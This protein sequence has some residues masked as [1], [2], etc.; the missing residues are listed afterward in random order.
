MKLILNK[1]SKHKKE[2]K[3]FCLLICKHVICLV[4]Y[5]NF[6]IEGIMGMKMK[7]MKLKNFVNFVDFEIEFNGDLTRLVGVNKSGKTTLGLTAVWAAFKGIAENGAEGKLIGDRFRFIGTSGNS[8]DI[9]ITLI[10]QKTNSE[11]KVKNHITKNGNKIT[12]DAP[13]DYSIDSD[14]VKNLLSVSF[15]SAKHFTQLSAKEQALALGIDT[16]SF[17]NTLANL[18][19]EYTDI[20]RAV[21]SFGDITVP[22]KVEKVSISSLLEDKKKIDTFNQRQDSSQKAIDSI[23]QEISASQLRRKEI[24]DE[25][26]R[27]NEKK[28]SI[29]QEIEYKKNKISKL[30]IPEPRK[31]VGEI[32]FKIE[33]AESNNAKADAY[34]VALAKQNNKATVQ[35][36]LEENKAEQS[37]VVNARLEY[38][39]KFD[40]GF[41]GLSVGDDGG[42]L[43]R[44]RPL[45]D[46][47]FSKGELEVLIAKLYMYKNPELKVRFIDDFELLDDENQE[48]LIQEMTQS[49]FQV[50]TAEVGKEKKTNNTVLLRECKIVDS[51]NE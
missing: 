11:I 47:Y 21:K 50:I 19:D 14:W 9:E 7:R 37:R 10:D 16:S 18:K 1:A 23:N 17:D 31:D 41:D 29:E 12:F 15:L 2:I 8:S 44:D 4:L 38:I 30:P 32:E 36:K 35:K 43:Y 28:L 6:L 46:A 20:N 42:L 24:I 26:S 27:L 5:I 49:G 13:L 25:I 48:K 34:L 51:Y 33:N 39:K 22:E 40:F 45:K 3:F